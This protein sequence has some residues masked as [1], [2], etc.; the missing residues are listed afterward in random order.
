MNFFWKKTVS[1][2]K[3]RTNLKNSNNAVRK[4]KFGPG[5][6]VKKKIGRARRT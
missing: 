4:T 2:F 6:K 3:I 5:V 1:N